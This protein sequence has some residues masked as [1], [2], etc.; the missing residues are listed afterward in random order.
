MNKPVLWIVSLGSLALLAIA[1]VYFSTPA[2]QLPHF[3]PGYD[4]T[5]TKTHVKHGIAALLLA[6]AAAAYVW[7][8]SK[9]NSASVKEN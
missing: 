3:F 8:G 1:I 4:S 2:Q 5:L 9:P 6:L 7:F